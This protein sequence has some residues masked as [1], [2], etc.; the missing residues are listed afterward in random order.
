M[1]TLLGGQ[2]GTFATAKQMFAANAGAWVEIPLGGGSSWT[3]PAD[4][5]ATNVA[6][7][8]Q[9]IQLLM[10]VGADA[11]V[12]SNRTMA[13]TVSPGFTVNWGDGTAPQNFATG[14]TATHLYDPTT[15]AGTLT[16]DGFLQA[17]ITITP[18][19]GNLTAL[20]FGTGY[21]AGKTYRN[22]VT[23][24]VVGPTTLT[25]FNLASTTVVLQRVEFKSPLTLATGANLFTLCSM[26][27]EVAGEIIIT[28]SAVNLMFNGCT[29]LSKFPKLTFT[30]TNI[31][32]TSMFA[33]CTAMVEPPPFNCANITTWASMFINCYTMKRVFAGF[34]VAAGTNLSS[35]FSGCSALETLPTLTTNVSTAG[36]SMFVNCQVIRKIRMTSTVAM[37]NVAN[38]FQNCFALENVTGLD[39]SNVSSAVNLSVLL[40]G[41]YRLAE[42]RFLAGKG[43]KFSWT[44]FG[45]VDA[46]GLN[47]IYTQLPVT[48]GQTI[49]VTQVAG[50]LADDPTIATAKGWTV[51]GS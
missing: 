2:A 31:N 16:S 9:K 36:N 45:Q 18:Q 40:T 34:D 21:Y 48:S 50:T 3:R 5:L 23:E 49:T 20:Q 22:P 37:T 28:G 44:L 17:L 19:A 32:A 13:V 38:M 26:L 11:A 10:L 24:I 43:P 25:T 27:R 51:T 15:L 39:F 30:G 14:V 41:C 12:E 1:A 35:M 46:A 47:D 42:F 29:V 7:G 4:W 8:E 6:V 33:A